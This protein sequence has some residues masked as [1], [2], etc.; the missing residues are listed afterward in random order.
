MPPQ[1]KD[2]N[3]FIYA[4]SST[5]D[6]DIAGIVGV[7][8]EPVYCLHQDGLSAVV[9]NLSKAKVRPDRRNIMAHREVLDSVM[10]QSHAVLPMRF[11]VV[12]QG[13]QSVKKLLSANASVISEQIQRV[14]NREE[15]GLKVTWDVDNIYEY[16]VTTHP[17]LRQARDML[18]GSGASAS[19]E[20]KIE[21]GRVYQHLLDEERKKYTDQVTDILKNYCA[22]IVPNPLKK[23]GE[24]M[25]LSCLIERGKQEHF[26]QG[27]FAAAKSFDNNYLFNYTGPWAPHSFVSLELQMPQKAAFH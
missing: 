9:S 5:I 10:K 13:R 23:E 17:A 21:L 16:F 7:N 20:Q 25:N 27:V 12:A 19:R 22:E 26:E 3:T 18:L 14:Y 15:M 11:G 4:I 2:R 8:K 6:T 1:I 24:V